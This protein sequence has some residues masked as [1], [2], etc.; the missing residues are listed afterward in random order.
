M[1]GRALETVGRWRSGG[2]S[3]TAGLPVWRHGV[4]WPCRNKHQ[5]DDDGGH[6]AL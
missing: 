5:E 2:R 6:S 1:L 4:D 3:L